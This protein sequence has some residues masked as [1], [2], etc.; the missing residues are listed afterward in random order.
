[1]YDAV[2]STIGDQQVGKQRG[3]GA[4]N[5]EDCAAI[6]DFGNGIL[7]GSR[8]AGS[9]PATPSVRRRRQPRASMAARTGGRSRTSGRSPRLSS[10][11]AL[12]QCRIA[13]QHHVRHGPQLRRAGRTRTGARNG[14][15]RRHDGG[16][17]APRAAVPDARG[18]NRDHRAKRAE[19]ALAS[20]DPSGRSESIG[21]RR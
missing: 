18:L 21:A 4:T 12:G 17:R 9:S 20:L 5:E 16:R 3:W 11:A 1:M 14:G 15:R 6:L 10:F 2:R 7:S 13:F 19:R 8:E